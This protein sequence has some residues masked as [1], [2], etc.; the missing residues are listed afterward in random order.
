MLYQRRSMI[1]ESEYEKK[2]GVKPTQWD[3]YLRIISL[4][5]LKYRVGNVVT[6]SI[7]GEPTQY[8]KVEQWAF[9]QYLGTAKPKRTKR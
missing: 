8:A 1:S 9:R 2:V 5:E 7:G 4:A 3:K 6:V